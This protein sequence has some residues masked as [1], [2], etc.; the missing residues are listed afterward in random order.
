M[1]V[2]EVNVQTKELLGFLKCEKVEYRALGEILQYKQPSKYIVKDTNY[3]NNFETPVLT[4]GA[5]FILGYTNETSGIYKANKENPCIIFDDF[6]TSF[7]WVD[8]PFKIKSSA[9]KILI[10]NCHLIKTFNFK[11][12]F[13]AM[14]CIKYQPIEHARQYIQTYSQFQIPLP[15]LEIRNEIVKILDTFTELETELRARRKQYEYYRNKLLSKEE[16]AKRG[17]VKLM[18][19]GEVFHIKNGYTPSKAKKE[20]W[21]NGTIPWFRMEN[22]RT[23]GR[24][25]KDSIQHITQEAVKGGKLFP[26]NSLIIATTATI[27][28][29]ALIIVDYLSNQQFTCLSLKSELLDSV[30]MKFM[31]YYGFIL[32]QWCKQNVNVSGFAS[33]DMSKFKNFPIPLPPLSVQNEIVKILDKFDTLVNDL[34][35]GIPAEIAARRKQYEYYRE[36]LLSFKEKV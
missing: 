28:E 29:H 11:F 22:I 20:Y 16:L 32:G 17:E 34:S 14:K 33:V 23:N 10:P 27:G 5:S 8:F 24:I 2:K 6:T 15:P 25:L 1:Q 4:A 3:N 26:A 7:H 35:K 12:V 21:E 13:Y 9:M 31:F 19:L 18:S 36:K 30:N